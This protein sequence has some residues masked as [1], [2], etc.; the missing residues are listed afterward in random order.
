MK[1]VGRRMRL[2][3][4]GFWWTV[5]CCI[6]VPEEDAV[7]A[8]GLYACVSYKRFVPDPELPYVQAGGGLEGRQHS[9]RRL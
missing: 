6:S 2:F 9:M 5:L 4:M 7:L 8:L 1:A 3:V